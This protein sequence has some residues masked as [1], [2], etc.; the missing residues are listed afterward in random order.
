MFVVVAAPFLAVSACVRVKPYERETLSLRCMTN[1]GE[2][3]ESKFRQ[4]WQESRE[5]SLG[6]LGVAGGGCGCN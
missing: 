1:E 2:Q 6:G 4:H 3:A 5:G